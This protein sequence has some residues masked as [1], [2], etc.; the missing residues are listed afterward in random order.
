MVKLQNNANNQ[1]QK[2]NTA[3]FFCTN[4]QN[5]G[6]NFRCQFIAFSQAECH[7]Q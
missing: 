7:G 1:I 2:L 5:C 6:K 3:A 4:V